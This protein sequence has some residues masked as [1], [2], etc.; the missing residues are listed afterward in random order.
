MKI[1]RLG[2]TLTVSAVGV[3]C[4]GMSEFNG[5]RN[6]DESTKV[7]HRAIELGM[8]FLGTADVYGMGH[9]EQLVG[10]AI[11]DRRDKVVLAT[12]FGNVR[13]ADGAW[14]DVS[15]KA[16][17]VRQACDTSLKRLGVD[18]I[19]LYY[20][21]RVDDKVPIDETIGAMKQLVEAGKVRYL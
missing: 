12:K 5:P 6:D 18:A 11:R 10:R 20:Q 16:D 3:G 15:G 13:A 21:H 7:I 1:R 4:M 2:Q 8:F 9:N 19:D 17:Y 14:I